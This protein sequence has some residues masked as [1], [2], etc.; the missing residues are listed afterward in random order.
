MERIQPY[1]LAV[2][3]SVTATATCVDNGKSV[4]IRGIPAWRSSDESVAKVSA[5]IDGMTTKISGVG[6]GEA[7]V[8]LDGMT[9]EG[10]KSARA[11][12]FYVDSA[13]V[14][15]ALRTLDEFVGQERLKRAFAEKI[16]AAKALRTALPHLLLCGP[17]DSGKA[18]LARLL[19]KA[20]G[21]LCQ[22]ATASVLSGPRELCPYLTNARDGSILVIE[23]LD[24]LSKKTCQF[25][26]P[27]LE[28]GKMD[29]ILEDGPSARCLSLPLRQFCV[30][31]TTSQPSR[32]SRLLQPWFCVFDLEPYTLVE[33][34]RR[35]HMFAERAGLQICEESL[36]IVIDRCGGSP[37][38][39]KALFKK[40]RRHFDG[41]QN[42]ALGPEKMSQLLSFLG[43]ERKHTSLRLAENLDE[44]SGPEFEEFVAQIFRRKGFIVEFTEVTGDHGIDLLMQ[45]ENGRSV[46]QCKRWKGS[47]GEP[48]IRDFYGAM[49]NSEAQTGFFVTTA[50]FTQSAIEFVNGKP[51]TL[52][53]MNKLLTM[54]EALA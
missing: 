43:Y 3:N 1:R 9:D 28:N 26:A 41:N 37:G 2:G 8:F 18:L 11:I 25:L 15:A 44:M 16:S 36:R 47:V 14:I 51:I 13:D 24:A 39:A 22:I 17:P 42:T 10:P 53:D 46:V 45:N 19:A 12:H 5:S 38:H 27:A 29:V 48:E 35:V 7:D 32:V 23:D 20:Q 54:Q 50:H 52:I 6:R 34:S 4:P 49:I 31:A 33:Q 40:I 21:T 30:V